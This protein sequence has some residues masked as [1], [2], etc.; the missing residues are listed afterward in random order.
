MIHAAHLALPAPGL[1][2]EIPSLYAVPDGEWGCII[3][4]PIV[5]VCLNGL[6]LACAE[7]FGTDG[8]SIPEWLPIKKE[9]P[10]STGSHVHDCTFCTAL[11]WELTETG[12][13]HC[14]RV[15]RAEADEAWRQGHFVK[16]HTKAAG[17][18]LTE[19]HHD[20]LHAFSWKAW[21]GYEKNRK[22]NHAEEVSAIGRRCERA[23]W[24]LL[25]EGVG[26]VEDEHGF[27]RM[28]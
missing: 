26:A 17:S 13:L 6:I 8:T 4:S 23:V 2:P 14:R 27:A 7:K 3:I 22:G 21:H 24:K 12:G 5:Q 16:R 20:M 11:G 19:A 1:Y 28:A 9:G 25:T 18:F 10:W 15:S